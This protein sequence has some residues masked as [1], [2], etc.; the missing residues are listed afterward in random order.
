M[1]PLSRAIL[2]LQRFQKDLYSVAV[3]GLKHYR[4]SKESKNTGIDL[5]YAW[6]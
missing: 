2:T 5:I 1:V 4:L 6:D 3:I